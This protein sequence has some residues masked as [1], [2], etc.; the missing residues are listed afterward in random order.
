MIT[1]IDEVAQPAWETATVNL[2][3]GDIGSLGMA[4][5][6]PFGRV[7][8]HGRDFR[9]TGD[10]TIEENRVIGGNGTLNGKWL[11]GTGF[12]VG[13]GANM[14]SST[15]WVVP[16]PSAVILWSFM[17]LLG[18]VCWQRRRKTWT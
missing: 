8:F 18:F 12:E 2:F 4:A 11:D 14:P 5:P 6:G 15:I 1:E 7:T 9:A 13:I 16:E 10:L 3:G 17:A